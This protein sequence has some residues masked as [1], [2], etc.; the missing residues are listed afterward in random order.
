M[1]AKSILALAAA[2]ALGTAWITTDASAF[3]GN[4]G[5]S[6]MG[7]GGGFRGGFGGGPFVPGGA[8]RGGFARGAFFRPDIRADRR[9]IRRDRFDLRRDRR[10]LRR[11][12]RFGTPADVARDRPHIQPHRLLLR[13]HSPHLPPSPS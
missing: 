11:D 5:A 12:L 3:R 10:D 6:G 13:P 4:G 2:A 9:D 8:F 7:F 1:V